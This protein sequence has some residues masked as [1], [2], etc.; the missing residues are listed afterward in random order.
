MY[1]KMNIPIKNDKGYLYYVSTLGVL[2]VK[3]ALNLIKKDKYYL[4]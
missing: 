1:F 4:Y 3:I 2:L